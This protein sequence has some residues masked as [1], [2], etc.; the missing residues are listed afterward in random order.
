MKH[1]LMLLFSSFWLYCNACH[2]HNCPSTFDATSVIHYDGMHAEDLFSQLQGAINASDINN[3]VDMVVID[4]G[5]GG[6]D[7]GCS[8]I[9]S[10]E[11]NI[12]LQISKKLKALIENQLPS[13]K[14]LLTRDRDKFVSLKNRAALANDNN[15]DIFISI[16]CNY[17]RNAPTFKGSE[18]YVLGSDTE[19]LAAEA[20]AMRENSSITFESSYESIYDGFDPYSPESFIMFSMFQNLHLDNSIVLAQLVDNELVDATKVASHGI[21]QGAFV[22]LKETNMPSILIET[23]YLSNKMDEQLLLSA[24]GQ[25]AVGHAILNAIQAYKLNLE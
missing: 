20:L 23:G 2:L 21:K 8:G 17:L 5:H 10:R 22:V 9:N 24:N 6:N 13:I 18:T 25:N 4:P 15:A 11:K 14:V 7:G 16:H 3:P 19:D 12:T 1:I